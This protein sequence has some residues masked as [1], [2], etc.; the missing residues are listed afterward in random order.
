MD[1]WIETVCHVESSCRELLCQA[2]AR[3]APTSETVPIPDTVPIRGGVLRR[4]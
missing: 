2:L 1:G 4:R 3:Q